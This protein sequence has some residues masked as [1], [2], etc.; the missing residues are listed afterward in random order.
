MIDGYW[1]L[2]G[3][4]A[5]KIKDI[6]EW[7]EWFSKHYKERRVAYDKL[8]DGKIVSTIFLGL[9]H[10]F[11]SGRPILFETMVFSGK[12][13]RM[14]IFGKMKVLHLGDDLEQIRSH[15]WGE[16]IKIHELMKKT[17]EDKK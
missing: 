10:N 11:G 9:D 15:T 5:Y 17:W 7:G 8:S 12:P 13:K 16:A 4:R 3:H 14:K 1:I 2:K 6:R